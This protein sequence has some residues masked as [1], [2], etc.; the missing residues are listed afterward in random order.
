MSEPEE[1][2]LSLD[3]LRFKKKILICTK[4]EFLSSINYK[5]RLINSFIK[6]Y[7]LRGNK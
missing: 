2:V 1:I 7:Q 5:I 3:E 6:E 4:K